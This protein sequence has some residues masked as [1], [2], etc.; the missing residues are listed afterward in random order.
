MTKTKETKKEVAKSDA[1]LRAEKL[2]ARA[3]ENLDAVIESEKAK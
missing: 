1:R 2:V 3:K